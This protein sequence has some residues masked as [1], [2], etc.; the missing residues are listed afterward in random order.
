MLASATVLCPAQTYLAT[1]V[2]ILSFLW[3][4][5]PALIEAMPKTA[6]KTVVPGVEADAD[7]QFGAGL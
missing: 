3:G 7:V 5:W 1:S 6:K 2:D 4:L